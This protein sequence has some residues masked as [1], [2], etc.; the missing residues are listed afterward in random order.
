[1]HEYSTCYLTSKTVSET[2]GASNQNEDRIQSSFSLKLKTA[3]WWPS[4]DQNE[5]FE[6]LGDQSTSLTTT[7]CNLVGPDSSIRNE[8]C[9][10]SSFLTMD[11][12]HFYGADNF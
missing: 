4:Y 1:M 8:D 6:T 9:I 2:I 11:M 12:S 10:R 3:L 7:R 5:H